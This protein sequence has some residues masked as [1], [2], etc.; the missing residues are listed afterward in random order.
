M[1]AELLEA[2][3]EIYQHGFKGANVELPFYSGDICYLSACEEQKY[4]LQIKTKI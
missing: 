2:T 3:F 4:F 1:S